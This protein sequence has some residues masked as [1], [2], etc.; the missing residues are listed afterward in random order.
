MKN[1]MIRIK[2]LL[3]EKT[4]FY[5][6]AEFI[7]TD[8]IRVPHSFTQARDIEI[9]AFFTAS[10][11]WGQRKTIIS[12]SFQLMRLMQNHP[13]EFIRHMVPEDEKELSGFCHRTFNGID[14]ICFMRSLKDILVYYGSLQQL[15]E[16]LYEEHQNIRDT[17]IHFHS[18]F[19]TQSSPV[20]T[21]KHIANVGHG[22]SGKRLNMFSRVISVVINQN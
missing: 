20:R 6:R 1:E 21:R 8:P 3:E 17:L 12:K 9:A 16:G 14:N 18:I 4:A 15:F 22:A 11:A 2:E 5:N 7:D 10:L 19:F 13:Y